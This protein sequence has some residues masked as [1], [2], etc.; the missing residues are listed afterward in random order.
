MD[1]ESH[2]LLFSGLDQDE[3]PGAPEPDL[4][5]LG[6]RQLRP[7]THLVGRIYAQVKRLLDLGTEC[8]FDVDLWQ[9]YLTWLMMT[10]TNSLYPHL[11]AGG[12]QQRQRSSL[13]Q[14]RLRRVPPPDGF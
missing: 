12:G 10:D 3:I 8:G 5:G 13:C 7:G 9:C 11:R 4:S 1:R 2:L 6:L 14:K